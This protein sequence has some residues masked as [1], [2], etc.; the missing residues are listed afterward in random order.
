MVH[1]QDSFHPLYSYHYY[2]LSVFFPS[3]TACNEN[4]K[5]DDDFHFDCNESRSHSLSTV[6][7]DAGDGVD[8]CVVVGTARCSFLA[9]SYHPDIAA[10]VENIRVCSSIDHGFDGHAPRCGGTGLHIALHRSW[11]V[12]GEMNV[13]NRSLHEYEAHYVNEG[14]ANSHF[15]GLLSGSHLK[16]CHIEQPT[17]VDHAYDCWSCKLSRRTCKFAMVR[18]AHRHQDDRNIEAAMD[19]AAL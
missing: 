2:L 7:D 5:K 1:H 17:D 18:E 12:S 13:V 8:S 14:L 6:D 10:P 19:D 4:E 11:E 9:A 16:A 15:D 3:H